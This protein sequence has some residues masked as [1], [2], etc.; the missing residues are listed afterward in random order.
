MWIAVTDRFKN[1]N[2][3]FPTQQRDVLKLIEAAKEHEEI[4]KIIIF[5]SSVTS[6]CNPWSDIDVYFQLSKPI[7]K[8]PSIKGAEAAYDKWDNFSVDEN[9]RDEIMR[10]GVTVYERGE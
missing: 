10:T 7:K 6:A 9:L 4:Q 8:L 5:G 2:K 1:I 3:I